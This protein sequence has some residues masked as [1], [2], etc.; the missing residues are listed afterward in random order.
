ME[1]SVRFIVTTAI[2]WS[3]ALA[4]LAQPAPY[5]PA[6]EPLEDERDVVLAPRL[7]VGGLLLLVGHV[8]TRAEVSGAAQLDERLGGKLG[9]GAS[10]WF[11]V[12]LFAHLSVG[13]GASLASWTTE[14][15]AASGFS[16]SLL[17]TVSAHATGRVLASDTR[18]AYVRIPVGVS[19]ESADG[20]WV[21]GGSLSA[22]PGFHYG[23]ILGAY[24]GGYRFG[25]NFEIGYV[26]HHVRSRISFDGSDERGVLERKIKTFPITAHL[27]WTM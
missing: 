3:V 10:L 18:E 7:Q 24:L 21:E 19:F 2:A 11:D 14:E 5:A 15:E 22:L 27:V 26:I 16:R 4:A 13:G 8:D 20:G 1:G 6:S 9:Y 12:P 23:A 17:G 25:V